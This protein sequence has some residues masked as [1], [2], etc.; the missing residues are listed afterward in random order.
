MKILKISEALV[1]SGEIFIKFGA[2]ND[3]LSEQSANFARFDA[4]KLEI[5][6][7][8]LLNF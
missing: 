1:K 4:K 2:K 6:G 7:D 5:V 3:E 8:I